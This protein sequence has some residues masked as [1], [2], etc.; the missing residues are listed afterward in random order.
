MIAPARPGEVM[1][2]YSYK[3]GTGRSMALANVACLL[4]AQE[5][6][7]NGVLMIDWDLEAPGLHRFFDGRFRK[8]LGK[9]QDP[10]PV[11]EAKPGLIDL[12]LRLDKMTPKDEPNNDEE[13]EDV[14]N[15]CLD[16]VNLEEYVVPTDIPYLTL[17]KAGRFDAQYPSRVNMFSWEALFHRSPLLMRLLAERL[18]ARYHYVLIDSRT[19]LT[20]ISDIC[21]TLMPVKLV[22]VFTPNRQSLT[23]LVDLIARATKY[24][25]HSDDLRP[26]LVFPL[27]SR[28]ELSE[29]RRRD[30]WR[31]GDEK[32]G[33]EGYQRLFEKIFKEVYALPKCDLSP[34]FEEI[35]IQ[36]LAPYAYGEE[37]AV[38]IER[39]GDIHSLTRSYR[40]FTE[41]LSYSEGPW[42]EVVEGGTA[43]IAEAEAK[44]VGYLREAEA[45]AATAIRSR[46]TAWWAL[47]ATGVILT[48]ALSSSLVVFREY[49]LKKIEAE[50]QQAIARSIS[51]AADAFKLSE[52]Q[53]GV[54]LL[55]SVEAARIAPTEEALDTLLRGLQRLA[56]EELVSPFG[57]D[58]VLT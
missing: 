45:H 24:R 31:W 5:L 48:V 29:P 50:R 4:A 47:T 40:T 53:P 30:T 52:R 33:I 18:A 21:T 25:R 16:S 26:L 20:D 38:L 42:A 34:Y 17:M 41:R 6:G 3:G 8:A 2:F 19:G 14:A 57:R 46:R 58:L 12:F 43:K 32:L 15:H 28:V 7:G 36:H 54:A 9:V 49:K 35:Q 10:G 13:A 39:S 11:L 51:L 22:V 37:V 44:A 23:G 56:S 55:L 1:T 27:P